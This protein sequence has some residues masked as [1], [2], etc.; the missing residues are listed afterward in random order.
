MDILI[1]AFIEIFNLNTLISM[2]LGTTVGIV[3][4]AI[5]GFTILMAIILTL[6]FTFGMAPIAGIATMIGVYV[7]GFSGGLISGILLGI[8]GTPSSVCTVFDGYPMNKNGEAGRAL[9]LGVLSSFFGGTVGAVICIVVAIPIARFGLRFGPWELFSLML[10]ALTLIASLGSKSMVKGLIG[11]MMGLLLSTIGIDPI[12]GKLRYTF[13]LTELST[14]IS[15]LPILIGLFAVPQ[16]LATVK[17]IYESKQIIKNGGSIQDVKL[18]NSIHIPWIQSLK[19]LYKYKW[20]LLRSGVIGCLV[21]AL[22]AAGGST[23]VFI[24]YDQAQKFSKNPETFGEGNPNGI[25]AAEAGNSG[26]AGGSMI[27]TIALGIPGSNVAAVMLGALMIHGITP[28]PMLIKQEPVLVYSIFVSLILAHFIM[29]I[30]QAIGMRGLIRV[31]N[32]PKQV[33]VPVVLTLCV[34]G[35][36]A[37]NN[38]M[39]DVMVF[40]IFGVIGHYLTKVGMPLAPIVLGLVLGPMVENNLRMSMMTN[41][42]P[43]LFFT[44][45]LS[46]IFILL[47]VLSIFYSLYQS[48]RQKEKSIKVESS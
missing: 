12:G 33:V 24:A 48:K 26:V 42:D 44:R 1:Q 46:L 43:L 15:F 39:F 28:G 3:A 32:A 25:I 27:P 2:V 8:P 30:I 9:S 41:P 5:P 11:G 19:E 14:G 10:F 13:G 29:L 6:P 4:G 16:L 36:F 23:A 7:G 45:P 34:A 35:S 22:P 18:N 17:E 37:L 38:R 40:A 47:S 20:N 31:S 21:G